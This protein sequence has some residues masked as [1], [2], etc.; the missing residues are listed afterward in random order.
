AWHW[1]WRSGAATVSAPPRAAPRSSPTIRIGK[2]CRRRHARRAR[3]PWLGSLWRIFS[4]KSGARTFSGRPSPGRWRRCGK[5]VRRQCCAAI[6]KLLPLR[7]PRAMPRGPK[8]V[9][10]DCDGVLVD[11]EPISIRVLLG[12]VAEAGVII[13]EEV[14]Y[15]RFLGRSMASVVA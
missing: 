9:I 1:R 14:G 8:L 5:T 7:L 3:I 15:R 11:S 13:D 4:A 6:S 2:G 10:F 12:V